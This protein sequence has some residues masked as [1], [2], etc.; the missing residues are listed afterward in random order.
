MYNVTVPLF[1]K[2]LSNMSAILDKAAF[3]AEE[4]KFDVSYLLQSRLFPD[5]FPFIRQIQI[6]SD[7]AKG[8]AARLAGIELPK[9]EDN[10]TT[11]VELK[12]RIEKTI[13]FL[14]TLKP[15]E[16]DGSE[17]K[18]ISIWFIPGKYL[19]GFEYITE[20]VLPN[21]YFHI[22]TAYS[23]LR[24]NGVVIG[25]ADYIGELNFKDE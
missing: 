4:K 15:D 3:Y 6:A 8:A 7:V 14:Q 17:D 21:F 13:N 19:T 1:V 20:M 12:K 18:K 24:H 2:A 16:I 23:I 5:Q 9:M 11:V 22:T 10:E 25:K